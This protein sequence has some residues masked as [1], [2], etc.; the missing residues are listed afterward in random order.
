MNSVSV[1]ATEH[2]PP[3]IVVRRGDRGR[4]HHGLVG[5][6]VP[7]GQR[8][9]RR[10]GARRG[11]GPLLREH[12]HGA[13]QQLHAPAVLQRTQCPDLRGSA[14][15]TSPTSAAGW[16]T[17][18][19]SPDLAVHHFGYMY[20][21][22]DERFAATL[23]AGQKL[24]CALGAGTVIMTPARDRRRVPLLLTST[25]SSAGATTPSTR[26]GSTRPRCSTGGGAWPAAAASNTSAVRLSPSGARVG[27]SPV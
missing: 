16:A 14:P 20:L 13:H 27:T 10:H 5:G 1:P 3:A 12:L 9:L 7:V 6:L 15:T 24:Q 11:T 17:T 26:A 22:D 25:T 8:R 23:R 19:R 2:R 18:P 4:R 21:A